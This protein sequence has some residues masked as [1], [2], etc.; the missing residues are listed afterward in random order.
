VSELAEFLRARRA[1]LDPAQL[2]L[3]T[4]NERRR[5]PGLRREEVAEL[6]GV[7]L[8]YYVRLEQGGTS[9][10][11]DQVLRAIARVL[12]LDAQEAGHLRAL[13]H[14][15][16]RPDLAP[17]P[18]SDPATARGTRPA[19]HPAV[20]PGGTGPAS[21]DLVQAIAAPALL[22]DTAGDVLAWNAPGHTLLAPHLDAAAPRRHETRPNVPELVVLDPHARD[23]YVD[24]PA[25][26]REV[27]AHL[28]LN[29]GQYPENPRVRVV[30]DRLVARSRA[31]ASQWRLQDVA[32]CGRTPVP[33]RHPLVG[34]LTVTQHSLTVPRAPEQS[35]MVF[36]AAAGSSSQRALERL[37]TLA[38]ADHA[39]A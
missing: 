19:P 33:L 23:L 35:L 37:Q 14:R 32:S 27:A 16:R 11:S 15:P 25:K 22:V 21:V 17:D 13:A 2:G 28:R 1:Q 31:F 10:P 7:S 18:T 29:T 34:T 4:A 24:W 12:R 36:T 26:V 20:G 3:I 5:V 30:A 6:A 9:E 39:A 38:L 8:S